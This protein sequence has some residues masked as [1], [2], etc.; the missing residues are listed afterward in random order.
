MFTLNGMLISINLNLSFR[1]SA[2]NLNYSIV[3]WWIS[4]K[5][6]RFDSCLNVLSKVFWSWFYQTYRLVANG[7]VSGTMKRV[8]VSYSRAS[9][10]A[11]L[12]T[13]GWSD[14]FHQKNNFVE[15]S[16]SCRLVSMSM[17]L[18]QLLHDIFALKEGTLEQTA[19]NLDRRS[20]S[21]ERNV[22]SIKSNRI[23]RPTGW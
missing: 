3:Y 2:K 19:I 21:C 5:Q 14:H 13:N 16:K 15:H 6:K 9:T 12:R 20:R 11:I 4:F 10:F 23:D 18:V 8:D 17:N 7:C 1:G 22:W